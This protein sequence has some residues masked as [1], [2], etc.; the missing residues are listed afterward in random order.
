MTDAADMIDNLLKKECYVIDYFPKQIPKTIEGQFFDVEN[1]LLNSKKYNEIKDKFVNVI[2]KLMCYYS[3]SVFWNGWIDRPTPEMIDS[4]ALE[5]VEKHS[6][7]LNCLFK[8]EEMLLVFDSDCLNL[9]IYNPPVKS[10][11]I[12]E[13]MALSEGLFWR[14]AE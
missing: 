11:Q 9:S 7:T 4:I 1:Y 5:I 13:K 14:L 12:I 10:H 6:G 3:I 2:L 8:D